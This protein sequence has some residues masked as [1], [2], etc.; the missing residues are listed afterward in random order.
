MPARPTT[1]G[2]AFSMTA[3][4]ILPLATPGTVMTDGRDRTKADPASA[5]T[6][7]CAAPQLGS[8]KI[9]RDFHP[10]AG[11]TIGHSIGEAGSKDR[12]DLDGSIIARHSAI[13][14]SS[15]A[16]PMARTA[17]APPHRPTEPAHRRPKIVDG[18]RCALH[19]HHPDGIVVGPSPDWMRRRLSCWH[20]PISNV[21]DVSNMNMVIA[22]S[23]ATSTR[24]AVVASSCGAQSRAKRS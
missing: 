3:G 2:A 13:S 18:N 24:S 10:S 19:H 6:A 22:Q 9:T 4:D 14:V 23:P 8:A 1:R 12:Y 17:P 7:C 21:V 5:A 16:P 20:A 11:C 15:R